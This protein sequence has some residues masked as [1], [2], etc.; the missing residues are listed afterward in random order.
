MR[1]YID[2]SVIG[3]YFDP[4]FQFATQRLFEMFLRGEAQL[5][6]SDL[7]GPAFEG[8]PGDIRA[9]ASGH[10]ERISASPEAENLG[11]LYL[12]AGVIEPT[13]HIAALHVAIAAVARVDVLVSWDFRDINNLPKIRGCNAVNLRAGYPALE[14]RPPWA[15]IPYYDD[16]PPMV[17]PSH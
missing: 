5:V 2:T 17:R 8:L 4:E 11:R 16:D 12:R 1:I 7:A 13:S 14:I 9:A 15:V 3:G 6:L 10:I